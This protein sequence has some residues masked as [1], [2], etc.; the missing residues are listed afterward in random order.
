MAR[1]DSI[2]ERTVEIGL[3]QHLLDA[4]AVLGAPDAG[5]DCD[6]VLGAKNPALHAVELNGLGFFYGF[7]GKA[8]G[9][10]PLD[11]E[12]SNH[13]MLAFGVMAELFEVLVNLR[14]A[15][16]KAIVCRNEENIRIIRGEW[17]GVSNRGECPSQRIFYNQTRAS[18]AVRGFENFSERY[19]GR[20]HGILRLRVKL[21]AFVG[22]RPFG[23]REILIHWDGSVSTGDSIMVQCKKL[24]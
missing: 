6:E 12:S 23:W 1:K 22:E 5:G 19:S 2:K 21:A 20:R 15:G 18:Q 16:G 10:E 11:G 17:F 8:V 24:H 9:G 4:G 14:D 7:F 3:L 13:R